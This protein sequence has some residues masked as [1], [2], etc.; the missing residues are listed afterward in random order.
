MRAICGWGIRIRVP[1]VGRRRGQPGAPA[2]WGP[3]RAPAWLRDPVARSSQ[4]AAAS[5]WQR[6]ISSR[7]PPSP[8]APQWA[9]V[10]AW[11]PLP[12]QQ[13]ASWARRPKPGGRD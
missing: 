1:G 7:A 12:A 10:R 5:P 8:G 9:G 2:P 3:R 11:Q 6:G 13:P 4:D